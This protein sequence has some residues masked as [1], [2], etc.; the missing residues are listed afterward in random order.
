MTLRE[1]ILIGKRP[2]MGRDLSEGPEAE[3]KRKAHCKQ[4]Y[5]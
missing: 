2:T 5:L 4:G 3:P 1:L